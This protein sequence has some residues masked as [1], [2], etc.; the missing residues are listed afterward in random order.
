[1]IEEATSSA[2][3]ATHRAAAA[4]TATAERAAALVAMPPEAARAAPVA[5]KSIIAL[6]AL[7]SLILTAFT[8]AAFAHLMPAVPASKSKHISFLIGLVGCLSNL[9]FD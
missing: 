2:H 4:S 6:H 9:Y 7:I 1:V 3:A 5:F 8:P